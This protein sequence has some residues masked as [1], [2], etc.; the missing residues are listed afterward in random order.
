MSTS[1]VGDKAKLY[2]S[3][4]RLDWLD[5][6]DHMRTPMLESGDEQ[7]FLYIPCVRFYFLLL[8]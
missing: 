6:P 7:R 5:S 8:Q 3:S 1:Y 2:N 4:M